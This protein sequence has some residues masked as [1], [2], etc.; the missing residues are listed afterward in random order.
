MQ[1][2]PRSHRLSAFPARSICSRAS[3]LP[4]ASSNTTWQGPLPDN[5]SVGSAQQQRLSD[6]RANPDIWTHGQCHRLR[7][8]CRNIRAVRIASHRSPGPPVFEHLRTFSS[9]EG[10]DMKLNRSVAPKLEILEEKVLLVRDRQAGGGR[11]DYGEQNSE[12]FQL[13]RQTS[14][15]AHGDLL[16]SGPRLPREESFPTDGREGQGVG[17]ARVPGIDFLR[18]AAQPERFDVR[19]CRIPRANCW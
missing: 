2:M 3:N 4:T 9:P 15:E 8:A 16:R 13:Q 1:S 11:G 6:R 18:W 7:T 17:N 19:A 10:I 14:T 5:R 12:T